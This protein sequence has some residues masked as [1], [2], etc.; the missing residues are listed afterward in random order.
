MPVCRMLTA[1]INPV[2]GEIMLLIL[3]IYLVGESNLLG[4]GEKLNF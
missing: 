1:G 2:G 3:Y 4:G